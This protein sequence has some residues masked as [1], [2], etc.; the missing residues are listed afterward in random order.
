MF[1]KFSL[2]IATLILLLPLALNATQHDANKSALQRQCRCKPGDSC[3]PTTEEWKNFEASLTGKLL[4]P[5]A[6]IKPCKKNAKSNACLEAIKKVHNPFFLESNPG[7]AQSQGWLNAWQYQNSPYAVEALN[8]KDIIAAVNFARSHG[9]KLV[10]KGTG[11]DYLGRSNAP[12]SLLIWTHNMRQVTYNESFLPVGCPK[13]TKPIPALT[14]SAGT[15]WLEAYDEATNKHQRYVQ[16]GGCT[17]VGAAGGFTQGGGFGSFS[18]KYGTG[19]AGV[20]Q[21]E[22]ITA[23]GEQVIAN[24]CQNQDLFW[25]IRGGGASTFGLIT[26]ITYKTHALPAYT[27]IFQGSITAKNDDAYKVLIAH[28]LPF[29]RDNLINEHWGEQISFTNKNTI[30]FFLVFQGKN[31]SKVDTTWAPFKKW[32]KNQPGLYAIETKFWPIPP[33]KLWDLGFWQKNHPELVTINKKNGEATGQFWW[34]PNSNE[35]YN[36]WYTYQSW[37]LPM[38]LFNKHNIN[39]LTTM[40][41]DASRISQV[42]LHI[43]K[44]LA[45]ASRDAIKRGLQT[46]VNPSVNDAATL[47]LMGASSNQVYPGVTG[48]E[49]D[50]KQAIK[51]VQQINTVMQ[52]FQQAAPHAG[53]YVNEADYFQQNWQQAF[54]GENYARLLLIK[55]K[56]DPAG[57][58]YCHHCVGSEYWSADGMCRLKNN[59]T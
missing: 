49:P 7:N 24:Q 53:T 29:I 58:F 32:L 4:K 14:V 8:T 17:T 50:K 34:A 25:A 38:A 30:N 52:Q 16:G 36:Y 10:I 12:D 57:I 54:W 9:L 51:L 37:W 33:S 18:K 5:V 23:N 19:A 56:Y 31:S 3:W 22:I 46:A 42:G 47:L 27:G 20:V 35:T 40:L 1:K 13:K 15:R 55:N 39:N 43:N 45:G 11:H 48:H 41:F 28:F 44:G 59:H 2:G 21:A 26:H 6:T